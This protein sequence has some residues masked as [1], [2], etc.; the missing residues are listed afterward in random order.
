MPPSNPPPTRSPATTPGKGGQR[1]LLFYQGHLELPTVSHAAGIWLHD[2]EGKRYL[3]GSSGAITATIGHGDERVLEAMRHQ[4][5]RVTFAYRTQFENEPAHELARALTAQ[6][7]QDLRRVFYVSGGSEAVESAIK[8]ARQYHLANGEPGRYKVISRFP[9]YHGSTLGALQATGYSPLNEPFTPMH[10]S[11]VRVP[12]PT[13]HARPAGMSEEQWGLECAAKLESKILEEGPDTVAAFIIEPVGGASTGALVPPP[14]YLAAITQICRRHG[15]LI[16]YD[17]VMTGV[18]RTG[19]FCAYQHWEAPRAQAATS[20]TPDALSAT[21]PVKVGAEVDILALSKGLG[22]GYIPLGAV[23]CRSHIADTVVDSGGFAHGHTYAGNPLACAVGAA[24]LRVVEEDGL[25]VNARE[26]GRQLMRGLEAIQRE[27]RVVGDARG[28][29]LLTALE[30]VADPESLEPYPAELNVHERM[31]VLARRNGL[32][33]YPRR[34]RGGWS[35]DHVLVAPPLIISEG[36]MEELLGRL[37]ESVAE[38]ERELSA[39]QGAGLTRGEP[40]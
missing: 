39:A 32:L 6:L 16:I 4:A 40:Q 34:S 30:F 26:R 22:A 9:S 17:E 38:L 2:T 29:G 3:D 8:L 20:A 25:V 27:H 24:V 11:S 12:A 1:D 10:L 23:V 14:G 15:V 31:T 7:S 19:E 37:Q 28:L 13:R 5:Q 35:G 33:V 36:E 21:G 18:G